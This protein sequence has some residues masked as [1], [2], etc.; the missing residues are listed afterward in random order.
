MR[1]RGEV[2]FTLNPPVVRILWAIGLR[3]PPPIFLPFTKVAI[4]GGLVFSLTMT[5]V[6]FVCTFLFAKIYPIINDVVLTNT[7]LMLE[8]VSISVGGGALYG[9]VFALSL[10]RKRNLYKLPSWDNYPS[11]NKSFNKNGTNN[12][13]PG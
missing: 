11:D 13:L 7:S 5:I 6:I 12:V 4:Y 1:S 9:A 3:F 8:L 10:K 2:L